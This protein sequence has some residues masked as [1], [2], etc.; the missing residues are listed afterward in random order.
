MEDLVTNVNDINNFDTNYLFRFFGKRR[1]N[2]RY[3]RLFYNPLEENIN[4]WDD[5]LIKPQN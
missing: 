1:F 2:S 3:M 4:K 5:L